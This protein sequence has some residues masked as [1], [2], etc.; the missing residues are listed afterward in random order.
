MNKKVTEIIEANDLNEEIISEHLN[1][2]PKI[3]EQNNK[4]GLSEGNNHRLR[5]RTR[6]SGINYSVFIA[7]LKNQNAFELK[8]NKNG[9]LNIF[10]KPEYEVHHIDGNKQNDNPNNIITI[11]KVHH[12]KADWLANNKPN[13]EEYKK[14]LLSI[15]FRGGL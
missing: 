6:Y 1:L 9:K 15:S 8:P 4:A 12:P 10:V 11:L 2:F 3:I 13:S 5:I 14:F 7:F